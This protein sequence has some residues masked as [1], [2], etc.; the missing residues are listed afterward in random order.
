MA[1]IITKKEEEAV[2]A[3]KQVATTY[4]VFDKMANSHKTVINKL[5]KRISEK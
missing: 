1:I 2:L 3:L 5:V 4:G